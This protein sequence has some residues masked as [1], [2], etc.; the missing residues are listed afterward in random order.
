MIHERL[1]FSSFFSS[2]QHIKRGKEKERK[3]GIIGERKKEGR[4]KKKEKE[5]KEKRRRKRERK[6]ERKREKKATA[7]SRPSRLLR[8]L[9]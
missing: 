8:T 1:A 3:E 4:R 5:R 7:E 2:W 9:L 6:K